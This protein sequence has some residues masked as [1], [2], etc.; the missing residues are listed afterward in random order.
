MWNLISL[1][2]NSRIGSKNVDW[3]AE[4]EEYSIFLADCGQ[5]SA[6][7]IECLSLATTC[8]ASAIIK[9][10]KSIDVCTINREK[11][12]DLASE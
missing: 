11:S 12:S 1:F 2:H 7:R 10:H 3:G 9:H 4:S 6:L 5:A 8:K